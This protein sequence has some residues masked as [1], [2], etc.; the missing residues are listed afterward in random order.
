MLYTSD[1][2]TAAARIHDSL[3]VV[4]V[5]AV[6]WSLECSWPGRHRA[7][8]TAALSLSALHKVQ[9]ALYGALV[10]AACA[11]YFCAKYCASTHP[12][13]SMTGMMHTPQSSRSDGSCDAE[14][15]EAWRQCTSTEEEATQRGATNATQRNATGKTGRDQI[16]NFSYKPA[17]TRRN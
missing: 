2:F 6:D 4:V 9:P 11:R 5:G 14:Q 10:Q 12:R 16:F 13:S 7:A 8:S 3:H 17:M 15:D 1:G